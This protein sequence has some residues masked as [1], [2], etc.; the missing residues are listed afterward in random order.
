VEKRWRNLS[1]PLNDRKWFSGP[2]R[3]S[4]TVGVACW[5]WRRGGSCAFK[6][7]HRQCWVM[8][9]MN[10]IFPGVVRLQSSA[11]N[12]I[13]VIGGVSVV[14]CDAF[15]GCTNW[16][17]CHS[18]SLCSCVCSC[19]WFW[20]KVNLIVKLACWKTDTCI[21]GYKIVIKCCLSSIND[22]NGFVHALKL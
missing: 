10:W 8:R 7:E 18:Y 12:D 3:K 20:W 2:F 22:L 13:S 15:G 1:T 5:G 16:M 21:Y 4:L 9:F 17:T 14:C 6:C 19:W 11:N